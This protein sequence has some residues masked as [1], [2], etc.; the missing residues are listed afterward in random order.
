MRKLC[1]ECW[2][3][4]R[5]W[6]A[7]SLGHIWA[8]DLI[9]HLGRPLALSWYPE[10]HGLGGLTF[11]HTL[12]KALLFPRRGNIRIPAQIRVPPPLWP[13]LNPYHNVLPLYLTAEHRPMPLQTRWAKR[14]AHALPHETQVQWLHAQI[15]APLLARLIRATE[16]LF[17]GYS[18]LSLSGQEALEFSSTRHVTPFYARVSTQ[19]DLAREL[20]ISL[21]LTSN[22]QGYGQWRQGKQASDEL[23]IRCFPVE[24]LQPDTLQSLSQALDGA[25]VVPELTWSHQAPSPQRLEDLC[26]AIEA[27]H[28][29]PPRAEQTHAWHGQWVDSHL[30]STRVLPPELLHFPPNLG[31]LGGSSFVGSIE[32]LAQWL[33]DSHFP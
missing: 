26:L 33:S 14:L 7:N 8:L 18:W 15:D 1:Q 22:P 5:L 13:E 16:T 20:S 2:D 17:L 3:A 9:T 29:L 25:L 10:S 4:Q 31:H 21:C 28:R 11:S 23:R 19:L 27:L 32:I 6:V 12:E 24:H 30:L